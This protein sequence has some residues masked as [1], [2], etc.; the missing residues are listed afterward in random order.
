MLLMKKNVN[1]ITNNNI[2]NN[3]IDSNIADRDRNRDINAATTNLFVKRIQNI[4]FK[5]NKNI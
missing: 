2:N 1:I 5:S 3:Q 4:S